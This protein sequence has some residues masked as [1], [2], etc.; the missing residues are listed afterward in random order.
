MCGDFSTFQASS[1]ALKPYVTA[2]FICEFLRFQFAFSSLQLFRL[3]NHL[4]QHES[5]VLEVIGDLQASVF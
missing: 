2:I 5:S 3:D 4:I 1:I